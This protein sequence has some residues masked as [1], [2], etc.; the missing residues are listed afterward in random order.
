MIHVRLLC[1]PELQRALDSRISDAAWMAFTPGGLLNEIGKIVIK[2]SSQAVRWAEFFEDRQKPEEKVSDFATR[3]TQAATGCEFQCPSCDC[4]LTEYVLV[5][6][7]M[8][9]VSEPALRQE[10]FRRYEAFRS[11][12]SLRT[13][14][15]VWE[16]ARRYS[17]RP[18]A[19][20]AGV[21]APPTDEAASEDETSTVAGASQPRPPSSAQCGF[22]GRKWCKRGQKCPAWGKKCAKCGRDNHFAAVC[23]SR[24][25]L[26]D[27]RGSEASN[28][29]KA[30]EASGEKVREISEVVIVS[31]SDE[32]QPQV[33]VLVNSG[34]NKARSVIAIADTGAQVCVAG[35]RLLA[36]LGLG[37]AAL[38]QRGNLRDLAHRQLPCLGAIS[39][40][41]QLAGRT[42]EQVV[43][44]VREVKALF[45]S[46]RTCRELGLV[47]PDFPNPPP[48]HSRGRHGARDGERGRVPATPAHRESST[49][50]GNPIPALGGERRVPRAV[51]AAPLL[52][53]H[54]R[55][56]VP[57][58]EGNGR[59]ASSHTREG[60]CEA[61]RMSHTCYSSQALAGRGQEAA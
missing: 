56:G 53:Y 27:G 4:D 60:G 45:L 11:V 23:R 28:E 50:S 43:Y 3:C 25:V 39:C 61:S 13:F 35:P 29:W 8:V 57:A 55:H 26:S 54:L 14:C 20:L 51:A 34:E 48:T 2:A 12:E 21:V 36:R 18:G 19:R 49:T 59:G 22:C 6:K 38:S 7:L 17:L 5:K 1:A 32:G 30:R 33:E 42:T 40:Q 15:E 52:L 46:L 31:L 47:P 44:I 9:G 58:V 24:R 41:I 37:A 10:I 16:A